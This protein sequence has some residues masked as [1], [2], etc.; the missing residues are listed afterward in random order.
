MLDYC[1]WVSFFIFDIVYVYFK[2]LRANIYSNY[3]FKF[4][5]AT[6]K[7]FS[8]MSLTIISFKFLFIKYRF[9]HQLGTSAVFKVL[10]LHEYPK[11]P[12]NDIQ[13]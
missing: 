3:M 10:P 12:P 5:F 11:T 9:R 13:L 4:A 2:L 8:V 6:K 1:F 7:A